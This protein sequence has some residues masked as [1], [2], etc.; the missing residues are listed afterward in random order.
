MNVV[1]RS[2]L[3]TVAALAVALAGPALSADAAARHF[4]TLASV[5]GGAV[6]ACRVP[7]SASQPFTIKMRVSA[8]K[9]SSRV[10]GLG[11]AT[12]NGNRVGKGWTSGWIRKGHVSTVG[13]VHVPRGASYALD[14]G[15]GAGQMGNGRTVKPSS[16]RTCG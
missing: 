8:S 14:A 15:I 5:N 9:A 4:Q 13:T 10:N 6:Q 3:G 7:T 2:A 1:R 16:I 11:S 12:H